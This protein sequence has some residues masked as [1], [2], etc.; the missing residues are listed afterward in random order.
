[1]T[2]IGQNDNGYREWKF[3]LNSTVTNL[4]LKPDICSSD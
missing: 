1:M 4:Y 2:I 3:S